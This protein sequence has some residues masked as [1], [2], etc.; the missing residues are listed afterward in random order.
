M[1]SLN[2]KIHPNIGDN[3]AV[4]GS[5]CVGNSVS[6]IL[7]NDE[8]CEFYMKAP[9]GKLIRYPWEIRLIDFT[10]TWTVAHTVA[11]EDK[12]VYSCYPYDGVA[13]YLLASSMNELGEII[14]KFV[15]PPESTVESLGTTPNSMYFANEIFQETQK[16]E[17]SKENSNI[18]TQKISKNIFLKSLDN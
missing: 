5:Y 6:P 7:Y 2:V 12:F 15:E 18:A 9:T 8:D 14:R 17:K 10:T 1:D 16:F 11:H 13:F 4:V 3:Y